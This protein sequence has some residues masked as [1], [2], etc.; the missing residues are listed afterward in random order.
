MPLVRPPFGA[1][2]AP[3]LLVIAPLVPVDVGGVVGTEFCCA[4][5][6]PDTIK[7][8]TPARRKF[9]IVYSTTDG[10]HGLLDPAT[11]DDASSSCAK[12]TVVGAALGP[13]R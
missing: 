2:A 10:H 7:K 4:I 8:P 12:V 5:A 13:F 6:A 9:R 11:S 1:T 3:L